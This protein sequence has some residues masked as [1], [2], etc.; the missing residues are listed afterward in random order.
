MPI[1]GADHAS[2]A[3]AHLR[4]AERYNGSGDAEKAVAH[5]G[6]ALEYDRSAKNKQRQRANQRFGIG[7]NLGDGAL[8]RGLIGGVAGL[9]ATAALGK[10]AASAYNWLTGAPHDAPDAPNTN[11]FNIQQH[12]LSAAGTNSRVANAKDF[13][14]GKTDLKY[15]EYE[16]KGD[17][18]IKSAPQ[19][20]GGGKVDVKSDG[21]EVKSAPL[22]RAP[23]NAVQEG[24]WY[25]KQEHDSP[26]HPSTPALAGALAQTSNRN[27]AS[28]PTT[29]RAQ[30]QGAT[31]ALG[32]AA[33]RRPVTTV[34][35]DKANKDAA[36]EFLDREVRDL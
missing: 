16:P 22:K 29:V 15:E 25:G 6:R 4:W 14:E 33:E 32:P 19:E 10:A 23:A 5:F 11:G 35:Y 26:S 30:K 17:G 20:R 7:P 2:R 9:G 18:E 24:E 13:F 12:P 28:L 27:G 21:Q 1:A 34:N 8:S 31:L 3:S 36:N